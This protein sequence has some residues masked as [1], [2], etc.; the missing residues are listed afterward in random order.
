MTFGGGVFF[1]SRVHVSV[2]LSSALSRYVCGLE[3]HSYFV[4]PTG[5]SDIQASPTLLSLVLPHILL[6]PFWP[7]SFSNTL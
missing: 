6:R 2:I 5:W 3:T 1:H 7:M 4:K